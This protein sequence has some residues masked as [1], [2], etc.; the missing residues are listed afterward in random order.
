MRS[1]LPEVVAEI[2]RAIG[3]ANSKVARVEQIKKWIIVP[4]EWSP[5][6]GEM[7]A[8][9]KLKRNVVLDNYAAEIEALYTGV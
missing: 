5:E 6:T 7:T 3:E 8:S 9:L 1:A 2:E 4:D